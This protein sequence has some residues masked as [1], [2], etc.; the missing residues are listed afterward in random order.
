MVYH[1]KNRVR[2]WRKKYR[3][4]ILVFIS[5]LSFVHSYPNERHTIT[6]YFL[7]QLFTLMMVYVC[8]I[9][10]T[11]L[12]SFFFSCHDLIGIGFIHNRSYFT[13]MDELIL[14]KTESI[15]IEIKRCMIRAVELHIR[16]S[17]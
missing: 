7:K 6:E 9:K 14:K 2:F 3:F 11:L 4:I 15:S 12:G 10:I 1:R 17:E 5:A 8:S 16:Q 13:E